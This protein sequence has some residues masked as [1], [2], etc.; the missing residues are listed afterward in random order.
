MKDFER[1]TGPYVG[2]PGKGSQKVVATFRHQRRYRCAEVP[3][4]SQ[5]YII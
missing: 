2:G 4:F 1:L 3:D 5:G